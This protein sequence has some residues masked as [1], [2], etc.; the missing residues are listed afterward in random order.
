[1]QNKTFN[2]WLREQ[3]D[4]DDP[5]GDLARDVSRDSR[6]VPR[7]NHVAWRTFLWYGGASEAALQAFELAW[8]EYGDSNVG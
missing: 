8:K 5:V 3:E 6:R 2:K 7:N 4:R 1:M